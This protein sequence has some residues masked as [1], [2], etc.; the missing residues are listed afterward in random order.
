MGEFEGLPVSGAPLV[1][2]RVYR[3]SA[4]VAPSADAMK[5]PKMG[6]TL[7]AIVVLI[8]LVL[9]LV[10]MF[11]PWYTW[12]MSASGSG[13][14]ASETINFYP[15]LPSEN[16]T[17]KYTCTG[18]ASGDCPTQSSYNQASLNH[19]GAIAETGLFLIIGGVVF[20]FLALIF[21]LLAR[22]NARRTTPAIA[23]A[24]LALI[25]AVAAPAL[26]AV[27]LPGAVSSDTPGH[28]GSGPWSTFLGSNSSTTAFGSETLTWGPGMG[29]YL[30]FG[31]FALFLIGAIILIAA[32]KDPPAPAPVP[33]SPAPA[34]ATTPAPAAPSP[35]PS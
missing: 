13:T 3:G 17:L 31:A 28:S 27:Q 1:R 22:G 6:R 19:T 16:G 20:G 29:W 10:A 32:R 30:A 24:V 14:S 23:L 5:N 21:G 34:E 35:P 2:E 33:M 4:R 18:A 7:G 11:T 25:L 15:G 12:E 26:F 8:G 9:L